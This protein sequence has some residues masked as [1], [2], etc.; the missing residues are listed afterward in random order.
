MYADISIYIYIHV[1]THNAHAACVTLDMCTARGQYMY[2]DNDTVMNTHT[3]SHVMAITTAEPLCATDIHP[4][5]H[6]NTN[7]ATHLAAAMR[8]AISKSQ[9]GIGHA[10]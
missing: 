7:T 3:Y 6:N 4:I 10:I 9:Y 5:D 1:Y 8:V 2:N